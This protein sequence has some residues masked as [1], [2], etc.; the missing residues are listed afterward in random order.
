LTGWIQSASDTSII[1]DLVVVRSYSTTDT[2]T[3]VSDTVDID[4]L[5]EYE[6]DDSYVD[7][8]TVQIN[9]ILAIYQGSGIWRISE[10]QSSVQSITYDTVSCLDNSFNITNVNQNSQSEE[11]IWDR[12]LVT[13]YDVVDDHVNIDDVVNID[14][15][16]T[17][18][19][20]SVSVVDGAVTINGVTAAHLG[21]GV[22]RIVQTRASIQS[23]TYNSVVCS[24]NLNDIAVVNQN[25]LSQEVIWDQI[26]VQSY[27]VLDNRVSVDDNVSI[28]FVLHYGYDDSP[29]LDGSVS[30]NAIDADHQGS[31]V[32]RIND[33]RSSV[34]L[35]DYDTVSCSGNTH[36]ITNVDQ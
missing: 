32:W 1:W 31:G 36:G 35:V 24:G 22:W 4:V 20:D 21:A 27:A 12:I 8:G 17:Y 10:S 33:T 2:R 18:E 9:S 13:S 16:L 3:N 34:Q 6:F 23:V 7:D 29:V 14:V 30:I 11:I 5:L 19:Y 28:D 26:V 25:S 15:T